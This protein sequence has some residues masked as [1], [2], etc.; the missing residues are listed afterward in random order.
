MT[1]GV[2]AAIAI[3]A[4]ILAIVRSRD[5]PAPVDSVQLAIIA[6]ENST[7]AT[8]SHFAISPDGKQIVFAATSDGPPMLWVRALATLDARALPGTERATFPFWSPDSRYIGFFAAG[9]LK[10]IPVSGGPPVDVCDAVQGVGGTWS[11][12]NVIVFAPAPTT[13]DSPKSTPPAAR[14]RR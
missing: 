10:K 12:E 3:G 5:H 4:G 2:L 14:P 13:S 1:A 7:I 6:A 8:P 9:K 11:A